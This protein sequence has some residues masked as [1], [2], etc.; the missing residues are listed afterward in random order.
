[1]TT[2]PTIKHKHHTNEA[3]NLTMRI[4]TGDECG[5]LKEVIPELSRPAPN[6]GGSIHSG[7]ARPSATSI[8]AAA[9]A[10]MHQVS[11]GGGGSNGVL[12][13]SAVRK[14]KESE[15]QSRQRGV[16]SMAFVPP[17]SSSEVM[18]EEED[19]TSNVCGD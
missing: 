4:L 16:I 6:G 14:I 17:S 11:G 15:G 13:S 7:N 2:N 9:A 19:D 12:S 3:T 5:L 8:Q 18:D 1:M 10:Q